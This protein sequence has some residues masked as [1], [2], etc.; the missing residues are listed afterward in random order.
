[1]HSLS[2]EHVSKLMFLPLSRFRRAM[3]LIRLVLH[4]VSVTL[5]V[6]L[7]PRGRVVQMRQAWKPEKLAT[8]SWRALRWSTFHSDAH[9]VA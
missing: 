2:F 8:L 3:Q 9:L 4:A 7:M 5:R 1:M 6:C